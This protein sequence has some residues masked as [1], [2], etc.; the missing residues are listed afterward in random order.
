MIKIIKNSEKEKDN[1]ELFFFSWECTVYN[2]LIYL[3]MGW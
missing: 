2:A 1:K 3:R